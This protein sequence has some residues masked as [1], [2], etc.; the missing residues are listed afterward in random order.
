M[1]TTIRQEVF[2]L[3]K[4]LCL[5]LLM[6]MPLV[7]GI[8]DGLPADI[9][10][11][12]IQHEPGPYSGVSFQEQTPFAPIALSPDAFTS[13]IAKCDTPEQAIAYIADTG[14][15]LDPYDSEYL[16]FYR[17]RLNR[18]TFVLPEGSPCGK[19]LI[20]VTYSYSEEEND[21]FTFLF[22]LDEGQYLLTDCISHFGQIELVADSKGRNIW[23][24]GKTGSSYQTVR[25]YHLNSNQVV[26]RYLAK[27]AEVDPVDYHI[28][29]E[30]TADPSLNQ[31]FQEDGRLTVLKQVSVIDFT[32]SPKSEDAPTTL[33]YTETFVYEAQDNGEFILI[34]TEK[35][36]QYNRR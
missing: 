13:A 26:L 12:A 25:W 30:N 18:E 14:L 32:H 7:Q 31:G 19:Q 9:E 5:I 33:L 28:L 3:K 36:D 4:L 16:Y 34:Q 11:F 29:V 17:N 15:P 35:N 22:V 6:I 10:S 21:N 2:A 24:V 8:A 20:T 23:L 1:N 27:G